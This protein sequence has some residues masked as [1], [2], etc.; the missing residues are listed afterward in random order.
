MKITVD[1]IPASPSRRPKRKMTPTSIT[2]HSTG[3]T[4]S[5]AK[6]ERKW[7]ENPTNKRAASWHYVVDE[8]DIIEAIPPN[9]VSFH[10]GTTEGNNTSI[11]IE[12]C[13]SGNRAVV[14]K[15]TQELVQY[16][17]D[18]HN[19]RV[20]K[21]HYDWSKKN[22]PRILNN[23]GKWTEWFQFLGEIFKPKGVKEM[24]LNEAQ[25]KIRQEAMRLGITDGKNPFR[26]VN[27]HYVWSAL[28][29]LAKRIEELEKKCK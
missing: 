4:T 29:P 16:L 6:G 9:E 19:I 5:N 20:V 7:L 13:E 14:L 24:E 28:I 10:A 22:C 17:M 8:N 3:N 15:R 25:E 26:E 27:Q 12:M 11:S 1:H 2:V 21:R 23:D 18:K